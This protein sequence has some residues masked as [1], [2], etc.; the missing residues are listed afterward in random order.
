MADAE[1]YR[2]RAEAAWSWTLDQVR[3]DDGPWL[4]ESVDEGTPQTAA[5]WERDDLYLGI[6]G[7]ALTLAEVAQHRPFTERGQRLAD[8]V[9]ARLGRQSH[10]SDHP[11]LY[12]GLA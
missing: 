8:D 12:G 5:T 4:P 9:V 3:D 2:D 1:T 11:S 6:A 10:T 7:T